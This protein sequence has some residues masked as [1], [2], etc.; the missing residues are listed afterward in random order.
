M[1]NPLGTPQE[2]ASPATDYNARSASLPH[3]NNGK[4]QWRME[5]PELIFP[6]PS[7]HTYRPSLQGT[8]TLFSVSQFPAP[9]T[10]RE[11]GHGDGLEEGRVSEA[12]QG[13]GGHQQGGRKDDGHHAGGVHLQMNSTAVQTNFL[14]M[15]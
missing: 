1:K 14:W 5:G 3:C 8:Y 4:D 6:R 7:M 9:L 10:S 11:E 12:S 13:G 15:K 2:K